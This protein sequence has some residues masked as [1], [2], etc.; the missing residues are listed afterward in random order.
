MLAWAGESLAA[1]LIL[2]ATSFVVNVVLLGAAHEGVD[3]LRSEEHPLRMPG[4][5]VTALLWGGLFACGYRRVWRRD[6]ATAGWLDGLRYG[7]TVCVLFTW[8]QNI[9]LFQFVRIPIAL[10]LGD[11]LHYLFASSLAGMLV[12]AST[13]HRADYRSREPATGAGKR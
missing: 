13:R 11:L 4:L 3:A 6:L 1:G 7:A 12:G 10:L 8:I 5:G 9:F 2:A